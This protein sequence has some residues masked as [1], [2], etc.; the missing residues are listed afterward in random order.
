MLA[1]YISILSISES[2]WDM[3]LNL[4]TM[5]KYC[6]MNFLLKKYAQ[7]INYNLAPD[8]FLKIDKDMYKKVVHNAD[9]LTCYTLH[10][11]SDLE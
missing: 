2:S 6:I 7:S 4:G 3:T 9:I 5:I 8:P 10:L 11:I 1:K